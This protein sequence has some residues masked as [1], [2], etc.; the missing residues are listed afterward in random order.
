MFGMQHTLKQFFGGIAIAAVVAVVA[1]PS[2]FSMTVITDTLGGNGSPKT[3]PDAFER[4]V[5]IHNARPA[6]GVQLI[7]DTLGGNGAARQIQHL[8][9]VNATPYVNGG[10][11][12]AVAQ[13]NQTLSNQTLAN[14]TLANK[15]QSNPSPYLYGGNSAQFAK[16]I[17]SPYAYGGNSARFSEGIQ[18][19][20][21]GVTSSPANPSGTGLGNWG[22]AGLGAGLAAL[23]VALYL[24]GR[25]PRQHR[26]GVRTA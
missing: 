26:G 25:R 4:A 23:L 10:M 16:T 13:S 14:K 5:A 21:N 19:T 8:Q 22:L 12:A 24:G 9:S 7:T 1:V 11:S 2:A 3:A 6:Q 17:Q 18:D 20:G 15:T